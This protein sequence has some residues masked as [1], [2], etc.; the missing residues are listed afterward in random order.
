MKLKFSCDNNIII[1]AAAAL[2]L[3][4]M[5]TAATVTLPQL[6]GEGHAV[7]Q[8][9]EKSYLLTGDLTIDAGNTLDCTGAERLSLADGATLTVHGTLLM[10]GEATLTVDGAGN[11]PAGIMIDGG[12]ATARLAHVNVIGGGVRVTGGATIDAVDCAFDAYNGNLAS[13][14]CLYFSGESDGNRVERCR[15]TDGVTAAIGNAANAPV[16]ILIKDC[17]LLRNNTANSNR[18]QINLT[19]AGDHDITIDGCN[20]TGAGL[21]MVGGI[22]LSNLMALAYSGRATVSRC[23]VSGNRYGIACMGPINVTINGC[24][25][26]DNNHETNPNNGGSGINLYDPTGKLS[27]TVAGNT[28]KGHL[29]GVTVIGCHD[30]DMGHLADDNSNIDVTGGNMLAGNGN[31][32]TDYELY[33][34]SGITVWAQNNTWGDGEQ[35]AAHIEPL[36]FHKADNPT[37]GEV[38]YL[39]TAT[40][41]VSDAMADRLPAITYDSAAATV[42][43]AAALRV[44]D[45]NGRL[46]AH[47]ESGTVSVAHLTPGIYIATTGNQHL[48]FVI[49]NQ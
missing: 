43:A 30:V 2:L 15:F 28:I 49:Y 12:Q 9:G 8:T 11:S 24:T 10:D 13:A 40:T 41:G 17:E 32:G 44:T 47:A 20:V 48:K 37:L 27:A 3:P 42:T 29:W 22:G 5:S 26:L 18:P 36:I 23:T 19:I 7:Q 39:P 38:I 25:L 16:G 6:A 14:A 21:T 1:L 46:V 4:L 33:N 31:N 45:A 35:D 34:N